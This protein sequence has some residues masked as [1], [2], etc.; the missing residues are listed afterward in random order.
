MESA[1]RHGLACA[2]RAG[3]DGLRLTALRLLASAQVMQGDI[4]AGRALARQGLAESRALGLR[5]V[6]ARLLNVLEVT[7]DR[8]GDQVSALDMSRQGLQMHR[9]AG[10]RVNEAIGLV[11]LGEGLMK[12]GDLAQAR[13]ETDAALHLLR[14]NGDR[15]TE[16]GV[17][18]NLSTLALWQ[19]D[20]TRA[21]ALARQG[22]DLLVAARARGDE[23]IAG[24][25]LGRA[26]LALGRAAAA[27]EA[28]TQAAQRAL[29]I[30]DPCQHDARAGLAR[31]ALAEGDTATALA[32][33]Q[34]VLDLVAGGGTLDGTGYPR[35]IELTCYQAL[36]R[37]GD[38]RADAWLARAH[39]ELMAQADSIT[40][41][42]LRQ[43]FL[44]NIPHH[45][46]IVA[47]WVKR[48]AVGAP[49]TESL[50]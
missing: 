1:A 50:G 9:D 7:A 38:S 43:G 18:I 37:A 27:R 16:G 29:E 19:G 30:E 46:E 4:D 49:P 36:A 39:T 44:Q 24:V 5:Q 48:D 41:P 2:T 23:V 25:A 47:A 11:N 40:D 26:E 22:L 34:Q 3:D 13:R 20:E 35:L 8:Q 17:L 12:L 31:V 33:L 15:V 10:D 42:A 28:Y 6:E 21:L 14:A 32:A 45:R